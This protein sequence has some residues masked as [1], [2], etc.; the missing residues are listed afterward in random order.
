MIVK[1]SYYLEAVYGADLETI[2]SEWKG[3]VQS[4]PIDANVKLVERSFILPYSKWVGWWKMNRE[5]L[6]W[7]DE[8]RLYIVRGL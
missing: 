7:D 5:N 6:N 2:E 4:Q 8:K 1:I 3:W